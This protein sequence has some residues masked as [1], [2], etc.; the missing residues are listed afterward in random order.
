MCRHQNFNGVVI[1]VYEPAN[2]HNIDANHQLVRTLLLTNKLPRRCLIQYHVTRS[3]IN[4]R[5]S[6]LNKN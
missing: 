1:K 4:E 6:I 3:L 2:I 5:Y